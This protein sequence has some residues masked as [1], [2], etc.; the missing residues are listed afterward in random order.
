MLSQKSWFVA[1]CSLLFLGATLFLGVTTVVA[2]E[3]KVPEAKQ[4]LAN[5]L[6]AIGGEAKLSEIQT[7]QTKAKMTIRG[8]G[9]GGTMTMSYG[10]GGKFKQAMELEGVGTEEA[11]SDG[12]TVWT[13][14][15][16]TG[17]KLLEGTMAEQLKL[18]AIP[19][20]IQQYTKFFETME[21]TGVEKFDGV[22]CY[23]IK[24]TKANW[25]PVFDYFETSTGLLRG[26]KE[27]LST[28]HGDLDTTN[29]IK[30]YRDTN[31]IKYPFSSVMT[32]GPQVLET[33]VS[34]V[35]ANPKLKSDEFDLP[36]EVKALKK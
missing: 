5:Y 21:C 28:D 14:S 10:T 16:I 13:N 32:I 11:G 25:K 4:I 20:P 12:T 36:E 19:F 2:Q 6:K 23:V 15:A 24:S 8:L 7:L 33:K 35:I 27:T 29:T 9:V 34:E 18:R 3:K 17:A 26:S 22:E 1:C 31:G 30:D